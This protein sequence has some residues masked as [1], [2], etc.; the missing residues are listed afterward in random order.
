MDLR[1]R[2]PI[3]ALRRFALAL[4]VCFTSSVVANAQFPQYVGIAKEKFDYDYSEQQNSQWCW[5][6]SIQMIL[7]YYGVEVSQ[8]EIVQRSYGSDPLGNLPNWPGSWQTI[9]ANLNNWG[10]DDNGSQYVVSAQ[11]GAG[12][13]HPGVLLQELSQEHPVL[14]A[15]MST[16]N[17]GH[18]V[19]GTAASYTPPGMVNTIVVRDPWPSAQNKLNN[20]RNEYDGAVLAS[21]MQMYWII[22]VNKATGAKAKPNKPIKTTTV[23]VS[24]G[25]PD[26]GS[27]AEGL[28][29]VISAASNDFSGLQGTFDYQD[30]DTKVYNLT[31]DVP[32]TE[33]CD[34]W[35]SKNS[36]PPYVY[37]DM[38]KSDDDFDA[39]VESV[40]QAL[41]DWDFTETEPAPTN[42]Y[43]R[44]RK[45]EAT[46][47]GSDAEV[48][49]TLFE[50]A[51]N[52]RISVNLDI[53][54]M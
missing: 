5:A 38:G 16:P 21:R 42:F 37:C 27:F 1:T 3:V 19:V 34:L 45:F 40:K 32:G 47:S 33:D 30:D 28:N 7:K 9:T 10:V 15:Y 2:A 53:T 44:K 51:S 12:P 41:P 48:T 20:G 23:A 18:A 35:V 39:A 11:M 14:L 46:E 26:P 6:A 22:R 31:F 8:D 43:A 49:V 36:D 24:T 17:S 13:P 54:K 25:K 52:G 50:R 4:V 29:Q